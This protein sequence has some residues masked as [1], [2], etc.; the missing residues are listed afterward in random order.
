MFSG[1]KLFTIHENWP[2]GTWQYVSVKKDKI[3]LFE[4]SKGDT[5]NIGPGDSFNYCI[6]KPGKN[7][8][9]TFDVIKVHP[10]SGGRIAFVFT[11]LPAGNR[12]IFNI[13]HLSATKM[14]LREGNLYFRFRRIR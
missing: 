4:I 8:H 10:D 5:L 7:A 13:T 2:N 14:T 9:G 3:T 1:C 6:Q 11:Y 12:R